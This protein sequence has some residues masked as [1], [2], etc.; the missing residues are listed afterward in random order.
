MKTN[1]NTS[2]LMKRVL[3][4]LIVISF[5]AVFLLC[6]FIPT[7]S[8]GADEHK[9]GAGGELVKLGDVEIQYFSQGQGDVL[10]LLPGGSLNVK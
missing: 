7:A 9:T 4:R 8:F 6:L 10:V 1:M 2:K 5:T 3:N